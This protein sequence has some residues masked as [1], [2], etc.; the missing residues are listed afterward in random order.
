MIW[1]WLYLTIPSLNEVHKYL[2][3]PG[4]GAYL[5]FVAAV[6]WLAWKLEFAAGFA[7]RVSPRQ[8]WWLAVATLLI[9]AALFLALYPIAQSLQWGP[10]SDSDDAVNI[11]VT[12]LLHGRYP[13]YV[14][15]YL[16]N[17]GH[18]L[19]GMLLLATPFV[20]L[21]NSAYMNLF[22]LAV[23]F[24]ILDRAFGDTRRALLT[25]WMILAL[26]PVVMQQI[27]TGGDLLANSIS[28]A[29]SLW[30]LVNATSGRARIAAAVLLGL[31]LSWR[32]NFLLVIPT[33]FFYMA[34]KFGWPRAIRDLGVAA[35]TFL[36]VTLPFYFH[37]PAHFTPLEGADRLTRFNE[38][39]PYFGQAIGVAGLLLALWLGW[40]S[41]LLFPSCAVVQGFFVVTGTALSLQLSYSGYGVFFLFLAMLYPW[42]V[43]TVSS[44]RPGT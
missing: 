27:V 33:A 20:L 43:L 30:L 44:P 2:G 17:A 10:G 1:L 7:A 12:E 31:T 14:Y 15:T 38:I 42:K 29:V 18:D 3:W 32:P 21:G 41:D 8:A 16:G 4:L 24:L 26:C 9:V 11:A 37:D 6:L 28:V 34:R 36:A 25:L 35:A 13:Y 19:P 23:F 22:W 40:R 5:A 39:I